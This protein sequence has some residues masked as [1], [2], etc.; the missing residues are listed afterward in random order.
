VN[1]LLLENQIAIMRAQLALLPRAS[2]MR[3]GLIA[4]ITATEAAIEAWKEPWER[5][6]GERSD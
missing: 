1:R 4:R 2:L 3:D 5:K 6:D